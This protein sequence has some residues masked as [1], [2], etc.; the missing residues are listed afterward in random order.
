MSNCLNN[1]KFNID[2]IDNNK[3]IDK[4][5][6]D[7]S[8]I[9]NNII[10]N[11]NNIT[12]N[13]NDI[14]IINN[15]QIFSTENL[16]IDEYIEQYFQ[17]LI[18]PLLPNMKNYKFAVSGPIA[19][20]KSTL[21]QILYSLFNKYKF[22]IGILPEYINSDPEIGSELL[23]RFIKKDITNATFQNYILDVYKNSYLQIDNDIN[24]LMMER[25]PDDAILIFANITNCNTP[26]DMN[27]QTLFALYNKMLD[28]DK[29]YGFPSYL[30]DETEYITYFGNVNDIII[31][32]IDII[33]Q[34]VKNKVKSRIIGL[35]AD[36]KISASRIKKR[37][38]VEELNYDI[39]YL[40]Q[41]SHAYDVIFKIKDLNE[42]H[43]KKLKD[44]LML[45]NINNKD[46]L[47]QLEKINHKYNIR[48]TNI[49]RIVDE[50]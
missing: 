46:Y 38:R 13:N 48:F 15:K 50:F 27:E 14:D 42:I 44:E 30:N 7:T 19:A 20:G 35:K 26:E 49:G 34:D 1:I 32:V 39:N 4:I 11:N 8:I 43:K 17:K 3:K 41:I 22:K 36:E 47:I 37:G 12:N 24:I 29:R 21:L 6:A 2:N 23:D 40:R 9:D 33:A 18:V 28:Y 5:D 16:L 31:N 45:Q 25:V 10:N